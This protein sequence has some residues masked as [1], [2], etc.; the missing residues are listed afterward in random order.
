MSL[1][2]TTSAIPHT[3]L[4]NNLFNGRE[5]V[6]HKLTKKEVLQPTD[7]AGMTLVSFGKKLKKYSKYSQKCLNTGDITDDLAEHSRLEGIDTDGSVAVSIHRLSEGRDVLTCDPA[8]NKNE[9]M[10][11]AYVSKVFLKKRFGDNF[12]PQEAMNLFVNMDSALKKLKDWHLG[13][14]YQITFKESDVDIFKSKIYYNIKETEDLIFN[15]LDVLAEQ[16]L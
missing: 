4:T 10:G 13:Q 2:I 8:Y 16:N 3:M 9:L 14:I 1:D 6:V 5:V 15:L 11:F 7:L 12:T